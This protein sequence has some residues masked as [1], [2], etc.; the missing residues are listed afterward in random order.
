MPKVAL[1][2]G[3]ETADGDRDD[4]KMQAFRKNLTSIFLRHFGKSSAHSEA[5][6]KNKTLFVNAKDKKEALEKLYSSEYWD[7]KHLSFWKLEYE[8]AS[9]KEGEKLHVNNNMLNGFI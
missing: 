5:V 2:G 8:K 1:G 9:A 3:R 4:A 6:K 7:E